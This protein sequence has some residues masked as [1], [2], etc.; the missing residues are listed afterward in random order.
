MDFGLF[1]SLDGTSGIPA[2]Q[3]YRNAAEQVEYADEAGFRHVWFPEHHF[4]QRYLSPAPSA[5]L[6]GRGSSHEAGPGRDEHHPDSVSSPADPWRTDR[7]RR[8]SDR[9]ATGGRLRAGR[10]TLRGGADRHQEPPRGRQRQQES[11]DILLGAWGQDEDFALP[12][13][14]LFLSARLAAPATPPAAASTHLG[15]GTLGRYHA[16]LRR[17][18][19]G[20]PD[21]IRGGTHVQRHRSTQAPR[22]SGRGS[23]RTCAPTPQRAARC[24]CDRGS[25]GGRPTSWKVSLGADAARRSAPISRT[26]RSWRRATF[27][28]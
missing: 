20:P 7:A 22:R 26:S 3:V 21:A 23:G 18:R 4:V 24:L 1:V 16:V 12:G 27:E 11:L 6:R 25:Q 8:P 5:A 10:V 14:V 17:A 2:A 28:G 19:P 13:S 15:R 9:R